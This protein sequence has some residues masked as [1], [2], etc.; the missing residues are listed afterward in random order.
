MFDMGLNTPLKL[1]SN[2][3][4]NNNNNDVLSKRK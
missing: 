1:Q 2:N 3:N 4:N